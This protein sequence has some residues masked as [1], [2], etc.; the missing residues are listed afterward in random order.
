MLLNILQ[1]VGQLPGDTIGQ[2]IKWPRF[3]SLS[4]HVSVQCSKGILVQRK[5]LAKK[6]GESVIQEISLFCN[7]MYI[8]DKIKSFN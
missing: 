5:R 4:P 1:C 8:L 6:L 3:R 7:P 2:N